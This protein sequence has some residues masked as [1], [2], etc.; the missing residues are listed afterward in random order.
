MRTWMMMGL[1]AASGG[2]ESERTWFCDSRDEA[3]LCS[4]YVGIAGT[5]FTCGDVSFAEGTCP[6]GEVAICDTVEDG[7]KS[8]DVEVTIYYYGGGDKPFTFDDPAVV[9][10]FCGD[11]GGMLR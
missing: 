11:S 1:V 2:C 4:E 5:E 10:A 3:S 8:D 6:E 9:E 7:Q